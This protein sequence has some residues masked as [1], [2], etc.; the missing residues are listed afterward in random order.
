MYNI[1]KLCLF[2]ALLILAACGDKPPASGSTSTTD[3]A[4]SADSTMD[5]QLPEGPIETPEWAKLEHTVIT[6]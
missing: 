1:I 3:T 4:T 5:R 2:S 6:N